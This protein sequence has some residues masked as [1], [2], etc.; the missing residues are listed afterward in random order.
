VRDRSIHPMAR[1]WELIVISIMAAL[2]GCE[3]FTTR[4]PEAPTGGGSGGWQ[5]PLTPQQT[6]DNITDA[7]GRRSSVDYIR[8]LAS[9]DAGLTSFLFQADPSA[10]ANHPQLFAD[11]GLDDET[12]F[13]QALFSSATLPL[14]S[15][16]ALDLDPQPAT[17]I[18]DTA[19][20]RAQ[21]DLHLGHKR[22]SAP[23]Q[24]SGQ[25]EWTL[26]RGSDGG[27]YI[28]LWNDY[29]NGSAPC[30]SDLKGQF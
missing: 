21:Y 13:A 24:M 7:V 25:L 30:F 9:P 26:Q 18:G 22:G 3:L 2:G 15:I 1:K 5:F 14:D 4:E 28:R 29:R 8:S 19:R 16:A 12:A 10:A 27:W 11:W 20:I 6:M 23:R 17:V